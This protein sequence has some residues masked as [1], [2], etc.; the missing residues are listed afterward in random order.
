MPRVAVPVTD[1]MRRRERTRMLNDIRS[2][3]A[4]NRLSLGIDAPDPQVM[5]ALA[6]V[7]RHLFVPAA[8]RASAYRD[9][10]LPIGL[11]QTISQPF[12]VALMTHLLAVGPAS[13]VLEIGTGSGYQAAVLS[14]LARH[15]YT[16]E[17]VAPLAQHAAEALALL[18]ALNVTTRI[19][20]GYEGWP[21][22]APFDAI[23]VTAAPDH[24]PPALVAQL[25]PGG[26]LVIP[27]GVEDQ[28][29]LVIEKAADGT[30]HTRTIV[31]VRFVPL[32]REP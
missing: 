21:S 16:I 5:A 32:T 31:P 25:A 29:L 26:R 28:N 23:I 13:R 4:R 22:E 6:E 12:I 30:A 1:E 8:R 9:K 27:V 20:D 19:G 11:G 10:P 15:V 18:G 24:V 2:A 14:R 7:P 3:F 17:I